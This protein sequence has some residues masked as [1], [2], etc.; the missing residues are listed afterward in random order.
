MIKVYQNIKIKNTSNI[1]ND[2]CPSFSGII[3]QEC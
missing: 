1:I 2:K 3:S